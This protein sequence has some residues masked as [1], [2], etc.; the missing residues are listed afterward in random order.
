MPPELRGVL[1]Q[2]EC[3]RAAAYTLAKGLFARVETCYDT[4]LLLAVV[5]SGVLPWAWRTTTGWWGDTAS[6]AAAFIF[7]VGLGISVLSLPFR[8]CAQFLL[9]DRFGFNTTRPALWWSDRLKNVCLSLVLAY[10]LLYLI[11]KFVDWTEPW[12]WLWAWTAVMVVQFLLAVL[13]PTFILPWF[14]RF[15]PLPAG[16]L[17]D[18]LLA[19]AARTGFRTGEIHVMD[20]SRRTRH[21]NAFFTGLGRLRRVVL[22]DTLVERLDAAEI[23]AVLAHEIGHYQRQHVLKM[24]LAST[25][26]VLGGFWLTGWLAYRDWFLQAFGFAPHQVRPALLL[27]ALLAPTFLFWTT[28]LLNFWSR[29]YE[30]EADA[31]AACNVGSPGPLV[32]ALT[33]LHRQNLS[34]LTPHPWYSAFYYSH[35]TFFERCRALHAAAR[36]EPAGSGRAEVCSQA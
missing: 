8:W 30:Y 20:G 14:N 34:N 26:F 10:P 33:K 13:G 17:R 31:L 6:A 28:P 21:L 25:V 5:F 19:L 15:S 16:P 9:E 18:R 3:N 23:E 4:L 7:A 29:R 22:F 11:L 2:E 1:S 32:S 27:C 24:L 35:P 12:W 36:P